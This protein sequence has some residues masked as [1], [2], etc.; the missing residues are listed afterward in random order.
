MVR[1]RREKRA[2][3]RKIA[4]AAAGFVLACAAVVLVLGRIDSQ[5]VVYETEPEEKESDV[6]EL[7]GRKFVPKT[8][9]ETYLFMGIDQM[10]TVEEMG[11]DA[12]QCDVLILLVRDLSAGTYQ[13]LTLDRNTMADVKS[14]TEDGSY[15]G[16]SRVQLALAHAHGDGKEISC[17]NTVE[18]VSN[19][20]YGQKITGYAAVNMGAIGILNHMIGGVDVTIEDDFSECDPTLVL[21][22]TI[23]LNDEQ[24]LNFIHGRMNVGDG[25]NESR[26]RRQNTYLSAAEPILKQ[27]CLS[28]ASFPLDLYEAVEDY[29]VTDVSAQKFSRIALLAAEEKSTGSFSIEGAS[30]VGEND[31]VEFE[32]DTE[33]LEEVLASLFYKEYE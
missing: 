13:T 29:M 28:D 17:E 19:F 33:S 9:L 2:F 1:S 22:E 27:R 31:F 24:A 20:L 26:I 32:P 18:A 4:L 8:N 7:A 6:V 23:H 12:G 3:Y 5:A 25:T 30:S 21:G 10:E 11:D 15:I 16:T 14:V